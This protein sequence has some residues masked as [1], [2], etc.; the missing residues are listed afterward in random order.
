MFIFIFSGRFITTYSAIFSI[1]IA[2]IE[3]QISFCFLS[4]SQTRRKKENF[5]KKPQRA[6]LAYVDNDQN[7]DLEYVIPKV[8][9]VFFSPIYTHYVQF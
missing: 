6:A 3:S 8:C 4:R 9:F 5:L 7:A 2:F 1:L